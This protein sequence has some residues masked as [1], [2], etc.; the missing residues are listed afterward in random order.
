MRSG[1]LAS[2]VLLA[3]CLVS[4]ARADEPATELKWHTAAPSPFARVEAPRWQSAAS[5]TCS[6]DLR[7]TSTLRH[8]WTFTI[9]RPT[10]GRG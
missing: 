5:C 8:N 6:A 3:N 9:P 2:A 10:P 7:P 1:I 4:W